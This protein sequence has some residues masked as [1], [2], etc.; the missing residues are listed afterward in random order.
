MTPDPVRQ[1]AV[2]VIDEARLAIDPIEPVEE[3]LDRFVGAQVAEVGLA[4]EQLL[5]RY[6]RAVS[7]VRSH[8]G[9]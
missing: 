2:E 8:W 6:Q 3:N 1:R 7:K 4:E 5:N 9:T